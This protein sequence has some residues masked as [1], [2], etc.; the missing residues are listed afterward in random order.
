M[1]LWDIVGPVMIG[2]SSS[3]TAG[4]ARIGLLTKMLWGKPVKKAALYLRDSFLTTGRGHGTDKALIAGLLGM[5][6]D[7]K[8]LKNS[9]E[10]AEKEG[11]NFTFAGEKVIGAHPNSVR[12]VLEED[13]RTLE[14]VCYS[15][16]GGLISLHKLNGA[17]L[18]ISCDLPTLIVASED[19]A[20]TISAITTY[21]NKCD[22]N[23]ATMKV[24]REARGGSVTMTIELDSEPEDRLFAEKIPSLHPAIKSVRLLKGVL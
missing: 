21:I 24:S 12:I 1:A 4:A 19:K 22:V 6:P 14:T 17:R 8:R 5:R 23:I 13:G 9:F 10:I 18:D 2:P 3:H 11:L 20:G 7:D 15:I 16:G